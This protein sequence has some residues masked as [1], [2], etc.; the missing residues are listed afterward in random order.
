MAVWAVADDA[1]SAIKP[2]LAN[3][4]ARMFF[5]FVSTVTVTIARSLSDL[6]RTTSAMRGLTGVSMPE[7]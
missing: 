3:I 4:V 7:L 1:I 6:N 5:P 2:V